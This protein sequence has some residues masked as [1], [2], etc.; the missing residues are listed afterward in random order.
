MK[1]GAVL[2]AVVGGFMST[3][4]MAALQPDEL[5]SKENRKNRREFLKAGLW[6]RP[7]HLRGAWTGNVDD[8]A[9]PGPIGWE[10]PLGQKG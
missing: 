10:T 1:T 2:T 6:S 4:A 5:D 9:G 7:S 8:L 3:M